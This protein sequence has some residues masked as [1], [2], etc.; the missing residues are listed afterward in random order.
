[1]RY[2]VIGSSAAGINGIRG[3]R[4]VDNEGDIILIS[5][6]QAVYSRCILH[7]YMEGIRD[8]KKL[9][10]VEEDFFEKYRVKWVSGKAVTG[11]DSAERKLTLEDGSQIPY[12]KLL[13]TSG[14][15][16][17]FPPIPNLKEADGVIGFRNLE[18]IEQIMVQA[19]NARHIVVMGA[20]LVGIDCVSGL[21]P[22]NKELTLV[23]M[24]DHMLAIQLDKKAAS[25][26]EKAFL[27][28]GVKQYY[29]VGIKEIGL[30]EDRHV[31]KVILTNGEIIPCDLLVVTA[32]IRANVGFLLDSGVE[33]DQRGLLIDE[34]GKT[35]I[36]GIY[37]AGDV[38][39]RNPIW[40]VAVKEGLIAG[41]NMAGGN[42][43]MTDFFAS[44]ST[45]NFLGIPTLSLGMNTKPD[46]TYQEMI[47]ETDHG[48]YKKII[49]K[50]G[51]IY[52]AILQGELSYAGVLTQ[53]IR[54]NIDVSKIKKSVFKIDYSD[55][56]HIKDNYE[57]MY[58]GEQV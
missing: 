7:H 11:L 53:I 13:I 48:E 16:S 2:V 46:E 47:Q 6:D 34:A 1:M 35:N 22:F 20:G 40:P 21:L 56:F 19:K 23:E 25:V 52:G 49:Y 57:F 38:T 9:C 30:D 54:R 44:K 4:S 8:L 5:K 36:E 27:E 18:D 42:M 14:S 43:L 31:R 17:F 51:H 41:S 12:D 55:F 24:Q 28:K 3:I 39:G 29:S 15:H 58:E 37:G 33:T 10:F 32:G 50:D 26:Y 45:M